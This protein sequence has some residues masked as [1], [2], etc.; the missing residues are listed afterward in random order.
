MAK[1]ASKTATAKKPAAKKESREKAEEAAPTS[2]GTTE[3]AGV[4][5]ATH[6][7]NKGVPESALIKRE[8]VTEEGTKVTTS[9]EVQG[10]KAMQIIDILMSRPVHVS[11]IEGKALTPEIDGRIV[12]VQGPVAVDI[13]PLVNASAKFAVKKDGTVIYNAR[14]FDDVAHADFDLLDIGKLIEHNH[15]KGK[16]RQ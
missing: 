14:G 2:T 10:D 9:P 1:K 3:K 8:P 4:G 16:S 11:I 12:I 15:R 7:G 5:N 6:P 13:F